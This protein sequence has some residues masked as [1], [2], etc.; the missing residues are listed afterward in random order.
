LSATSKTFLEGITIHLEGTRGPEIVEITDVGCHGQTSA[1]VESHDADLDAKFLPDLHSVI[2]E[3]EQTVASG[4]AEFDDSEPP[5]AQALRLDGGIVKAP[6]V[7]RTE[8]SA[9]A[10]PLFPRSNREAPQKTTHDESSQWDC[11]G[12]KIDETFSQL[13]SFSEGEFLQPQGMALSL[14]G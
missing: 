5:V 6:G 12:G 13:H 11:A 4:N 7:M 8:D 1:G 2:A 10:E 14:V 3:T 9:R